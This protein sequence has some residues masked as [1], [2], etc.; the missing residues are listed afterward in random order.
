MAVEKF[1]IWE[2]GDDEHGDRLMMAGKK[3]IN[4]GA[5]LELVAG[6]IAATPPLLVP[7]EWQS[8]AW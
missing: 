4:L 7:L 6:F 3:G 8:S 5:R 2:L 1:A